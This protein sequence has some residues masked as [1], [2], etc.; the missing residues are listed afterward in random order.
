MPKIPCVLKY[1]LDVK[2]VQTILIPKD[3]KILCAHTQIGRKN[4]GAEII[5]IW[6]LSSIEEGEQPVNDNPIRIGVMPTGGAFSP[7]WT[8]EIKE[9]ITTER[10]IG[11][12]FFQTARLV[13]HIFNLT[14]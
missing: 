13:Y 2:E 8:D 11:S 5:C 7:E 3:A 12:V 6:V 4:F 10:Y 9:K 14:M 1:E